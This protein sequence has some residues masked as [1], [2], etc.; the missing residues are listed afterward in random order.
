MCQPGRRSGNTELPN[1]AGTTSISKYIQK[2]SESFL[3]WANPIPQDTPESREGQKFELS[4]LPP[5]YFRGRRNKSF[6]KP[7]VA[8]LANFQGT[9]F[10][11]GQA[12][13]PAN[14]RDG[15]SQTT[16]IDQIF[17][18]RGQDVSVCCVSCNAAVI[19][20]DSFANKAEKQLR[21]RLL[22]KSIKGW[23]KKIIKEGRK[24][25]E[26]ASLSPP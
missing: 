17:S 23:M 21:K 12:P 22:Q 1:N 7:V 19:Q 26:P 8:P 20:R 6:G 13:P 9:L 24:F 4:L 14:W 16:T 2:E 18:G 3:I 11:F 10:L 25:C 5:H 15:F